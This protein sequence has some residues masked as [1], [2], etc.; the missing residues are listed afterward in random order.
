[1]LQSHSDGRQ[2]M[3]RRAA[4]R[5]LIP[6]YNEAARIEP[7][8]KRYCEYFKDSAAITVIA[9]GCTDDTVAIVERMTAEY[10]NLSLFAI[11]AKV[12]KGG[13]I[14]A[15]LKL[16]K[17]DYIVFVDADGST[18][19]CEADRLLQLCREKRVA[20]VIGS[21]WLPDSVV[22]PKQPWK[23]RAASRVFNGIVRAAFGLRFSDTQCGAKVFERRAL[24][25][26]LPKL[27]IAN[28]AFDIDILYRLRLQGSQILE[29]PI[30]WSDEA[31][32]TK[33]KLVRSALSMLAAVVRLRLIESPFAKVPFLDLIMRDV[34]IPVKSRLHILFLA[35]H[36]SRENATARLAAEHLKRIGHEVT[37]IS[38]PNAAG[39]RRAILSKY[40]RR[41]CHECDAVVELANPK[42]FVFPAFIFKPRL[43]LTMSNDRS[44]V[45]QRGLYPALYGRVQRLLVDDS[46]SPEH[47]AE[48]ILTYVRQG[49][50][51]QITFEQSEDGWALRLFDADKRIS[52]VQ[53]L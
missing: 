44:T 29:A 7:T 9:N 19:P 23:R 32:G 35:P 47:L 6:A 48:D 42:P 49:L 41:W 53:N 51:F 36:T 30:S 12:G 8:L 33:I 27:E 1:M 28:F 20:A 21:R 15:G 45:Q 14:R 17:E 43:L 40:F 39:A 16:S 10:S 3:T 34:T 26:I 25:A 38:C 11:N 22:H 18:A 5:I 31:S 37:W 50:P 46:Q 13:A 2:S 52:S 24:Y 4:A